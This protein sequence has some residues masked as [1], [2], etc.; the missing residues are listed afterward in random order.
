M[1]GVVGE[2]R[3]KCAEAQKPVIFYI[4]TKDMNILMYLRSLRWLK[5]VLR[6]MLSAD[7]FW[8]AAVY[9][10]THV[11][12]MKQR[13]TRGTLPSQP[14]EAPHD[15]ANEIQP[16]KPLHI[17]CAGR[18]GHRRSSEMKLQRCHGVQGT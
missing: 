15:S 3:H 17:V 5:P 10:S 13:Y 7:I 1:K 2:V 9:R 8:G 18:T 6:I 11:S 12:P 4:V 16:F 14:V